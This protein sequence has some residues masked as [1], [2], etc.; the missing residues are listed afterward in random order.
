MIFVVVLVLL[1][2]SGCSWTK[3]TTRGTAIEAV[4]LEWG[5]SLPTRSRE[6][7]EQTQ[8]E[9]GTAYRVYRAVCKDI[10]DN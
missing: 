9:I 1:A 3:M 10:E 7:T 4:C 2:V 6:D 5:G 8:I